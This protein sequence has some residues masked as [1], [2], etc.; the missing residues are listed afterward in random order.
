LVDVYFRRPI[1][2]L[3]A[4]KTMDESIDAA[5][6]VV[7][8]QNNWNQFIQLPGGAIVSPRISHLGASSAWIIGQIPRSA[9]LQIDE[10]RGDFDEEED[11]VHLFMQEIR[12]DDLIDVDGFLRQ[13]T[14]A[15]DNSAQP[16]SE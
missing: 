11:P 7:V 4:G 1:G 16:T 12:P 2:S 14:P 15:A 9:T 10:Q 13:S 3:A 5:F 6:E 8:L